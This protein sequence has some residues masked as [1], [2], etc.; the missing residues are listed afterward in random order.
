MNS[1]VPL[2][3]AAV[4]L[5]V[6]A[7]SQKQAVKPARYSSQ[8]IP[9]EMTVPVAP[10]PVEAEGSIHLVYELHLTN[11]GAGELTLER[12][13]ALDATSGKTLIT[14]S[15][16]AMA[17]VLSRPGSVDT[18]NKAIIKGGQRAVAFVDIV[19]PAASARIRA[20]RH[21]VTFK[22]IKTVDLNDQSI[23]DGAA[24]KTGPDIT[25]FFGPPL[26]GGCWIASHGL[27]NSSSHR[28][29]LLAIDGKTTI[30]QRFAIDWIRVGADGQ[31][32][33]GN[34]A[35]NR[36]WTPYGAD[37]L[38]V[39]DG[40]VIDILDGLAENDPTADQKA[41]PI[42]L[43]TAGGNHVMLDVG[44]GRYVFYAHLQP[45]GM[46]VKVGDSVRRGQPIARLG[47]SGNSDA[48]HLHIHVVDAPFPLAAEGM[49]I[50]F[51]SFLLQGHLPS[52]KPLVDGTG[53][54]P[55]GAPQLRRREMPLE[56]SVVSFGLSNS[57]AC[58]T[59]L[60]PANR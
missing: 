31:A 10:T 33:R 6:P 21:R 41:I 56:N 7:A 16:D 4:L 43:T 14:Y 52:L 35:I 28:R 46:R 40:K 60:P 47:N 25:G 18:S 15:G 26:R 1:S 32:F 59:P 57:I 3:L 17:S 58:P 23:V 30:A 48:P 19:T 55:A 11:F 54:K 29:T 13:D 12:I 8:A 44:H 49:P 5:S 51:D 24:F 20:V 36:N 37:V 27:A 9:I 2:A 22:S 39:A 50:V 53:W 45:G 34:P 42:S 38:A